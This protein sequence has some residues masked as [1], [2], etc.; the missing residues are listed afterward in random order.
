MNWAWDFRHTIENLDKVDDISAIEETYQWDL[1]QTIPA[2]YIRTISGTPW[3]II[4]I[5]REVAGR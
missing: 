5:A 2:P 4:A 1:S 3:I